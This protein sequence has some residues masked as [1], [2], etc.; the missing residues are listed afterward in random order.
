VVVIPTY[1]EI[2]NLEQIVSRLRTAQPAVDIL[3]MDDSSP[4]GTG[5]LADRLAAADSQISV[6]HRTEKAGLGAAYLH[7]FSVA[8][9]QG[10]D[11]VGEMDADG[12]H[13]PEQLH[14]LFEGLQ[15]ADLVIG[16]RWVAGGSV[17]NWPLFRKLLSVFGNLYARIALGIPVR[18]ITAGY[19]LFRSSTLRAIGL[20]DVRSVG[21]CFQTDLT[22]RTIR[23]GLKVREVP[24]E[25]IERERGESKMSTDVAVESLRL[26]TIWGLGE[27]WGQLKRFAAGLLKRS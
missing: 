27:R 5:E 20:E 13:Q 25:F 22:L 14:L 17:V 9:E 7:G 6:V 16:S 4:D 26:I 21:Y 8:L 12:S 11:V 23:S 3:I 2:D 1:N 24:I 10:Y 19:R 15:S 18:D